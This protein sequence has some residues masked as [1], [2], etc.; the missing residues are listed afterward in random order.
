[1]LDGDVNAQKYLWRAVGVHEV[2]IA[3]HRH[4]HCRLSIEHI[5]SKDVSLTSWR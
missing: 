3:M 2:L 1:M 4:L 5:Y